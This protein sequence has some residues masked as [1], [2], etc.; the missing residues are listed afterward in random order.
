M[1]AASKSY[2]WILVLAA[3]AADG[4]FI[5]RVGYFL[6]GSVVPARGFSPGRARGPTSS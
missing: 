3:L 4:A 2:D 6:L 5:Y 1:P